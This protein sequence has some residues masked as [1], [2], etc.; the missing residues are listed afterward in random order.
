MLKLVGLTLHSGRGQVGSTLGAMGMRYCA[1]TDFLHT[2]IIRQ[3]MLK[4]VGLT[5][6][7]GRGQVGS[8]LRSMSMRYCAR[9]DFTHTHVSAVGKV[10]V[11]MTY[12][13]L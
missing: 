12:I 7:S 1:Q 3:L 13:V 4:L 2:S 10:Q 8:M 11:V 6:H 9:T 5:L